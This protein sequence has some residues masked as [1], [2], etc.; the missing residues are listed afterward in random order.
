MM[1]F[2]EGQIVTV[3]KNSKLVKIIRALPNPYLLSWLI[4][5]NWLVFEDD[6]KNVYKQCDLKK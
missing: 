3:K 2:K 6:K 5:P 1:K 4:K